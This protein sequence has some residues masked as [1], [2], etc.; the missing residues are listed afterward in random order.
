[1]DGLEEGVDVLHLWR[2]KYSVALSA[3]T[4]VVD[5]IWLSTD[6]I[7]IWFHVNRVG[8]ALRAQRLP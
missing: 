4:V 1:V 2:D 6:V 3:F 5:A 8:M 7:K